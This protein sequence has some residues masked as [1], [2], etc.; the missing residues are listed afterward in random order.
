MTHL[1]KLKTIIFFITIIIFS[2]IFISWGLDDIHGLLAHPA[3][4]VL[5]L[6]LIVQFFFLELI[7][8]AWILS[9]LPK[10]APD[11]NMLVPFIGAMSILLIIIISPFSD[12][13]EWILL[14]GGDITRYFGLFLFILGAFA[15]NWAS[16]H[17]C[18]QLN[19]QQ[20]NQQGYQLV[21]SGPFEYVRH[22]RD[23][24]TILIFVSLPLVFLSSL[25]LLLAI[26][27]VAGLFE[28]IAREEKILQ[29]Q[30]KEKWTDYSQHT[31]CLVPWL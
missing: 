2:I 26:F 25:G 1:L 18:K 27:S 6:L 3:R 12:R 30:F 23:F 14:G 22:P 28:R 8:W 4:V 17:L 29:Q 31:K 9:R 19:I 16:I 5:L 7:P 11:D 10:Q 24:G 20:Q 15:A 13:N 21:T